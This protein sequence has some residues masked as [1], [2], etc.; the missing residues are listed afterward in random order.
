MAKRKRV[1]RQLDQPIAAAL[2]HGKKALFQSDDAWELNI[3]GFPKRYRPKNPMPLAGWDFLEG[4]ARLSPQQAM[5]YLSLLVRV[6]ETG[7]P[8]EDDDESLAAYARVSP[9][10]F[11]NQFRPIIGKFFELVD[12]RWCP[13]AGHVDDPASY[14]IGTKEFIELRRK[15]LERDNHTCAYCRQRKETMQVDHIIPLIRGGSNDAENLIAACRDC[16]YEKKNR[17]AIE[18]LG[19]D[20]MEGR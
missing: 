13:T 2:P 3:L 9:T 18:W 5:I 14:R 8:L 6:W 17:T 19:A 15:V 11:K 7:E 16:N 12:G 10:K 4:T 1:S 20:W